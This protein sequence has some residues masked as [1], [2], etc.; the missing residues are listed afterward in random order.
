MRLLVILQF[1][2]L[3]LIEVVFYGILQVASGTMH[4]FEQK[5]EYDLK[6]DAVVAF[7]QFDRE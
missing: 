6:D 7:N 3:F 5:P 2:F 1:V 4:L